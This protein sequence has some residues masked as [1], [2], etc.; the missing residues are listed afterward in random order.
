MILII[1]FVLLFVLWF[2]YIIWSKVVV[3]V[4]IMFFLIVVNMYDGLCSMKK[5]WEE[6]LVIYGVIKR[7]IFFKLKLLFVFFY[8]F[9]VLKI[10][11]L[12]SVIGVVIG[13]WFGV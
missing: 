2:G 13:E 1:V 11:V 7:D 12:F 8:F 6:F 4:L 10:V 5:E 3:I 9:L